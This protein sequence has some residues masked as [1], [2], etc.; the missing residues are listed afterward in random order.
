M[1]Q[2]LEKIGV[3]DGSQNPLTQRADNINTAYAD[4]LQGYEE[5]GKNAPWLARVP[6]S[7]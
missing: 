7:I 5:Q 2:F 3:G 1:A 6:L 4:Y